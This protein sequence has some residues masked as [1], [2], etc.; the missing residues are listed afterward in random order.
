ML[1][2]KGR[3]H[4]I[5]A[6]AVFLRHQFNNVWRVVN[7]QELINERTNFT[8]AA[9]HLA[10]ADFD[11]V[12]AIIARTVE[13]RRDFI[14]GRILFCQLLA[15]QGRIEVS[16]RSRCSR[17]GFCLE[18]AEG[19]NADG[20]TAEYECEIEWPIRFL[21]LNGGFIAAAWRCR[22][23]A[24][25]TEFRARCYMPAAFRTFHYSFVLRN[26]QF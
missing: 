24:V 14:H 19:K 15:A 7:L 13:L 3:G 2:L 18:P 9:F 26:E 12:V 6:I 10:I 1:K 4:A 8:G 16:S 22:F 23:A 21:D 25:W 17:R 11:A 5:F 20:N